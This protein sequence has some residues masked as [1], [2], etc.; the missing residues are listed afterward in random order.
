M[1]SAMTDF[2]KEAAKFRTARRVWAKLMKDRLGA[3]DPRSQ[4]M[5]I[6]GFTQEAP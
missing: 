4:M 2:L 6:F 1:F 5:R 3:K